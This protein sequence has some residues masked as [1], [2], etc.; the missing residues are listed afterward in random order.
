MVRGERGVAGDTTVR[1]ATRRDGP[2]LAELCRRVPLA[3]AGQLVG[4]DYGP[5]WWPAF[6]MV[7][8]R[9]VFVAEHG[10]RI[11]GL[12][13]VT[14]LRARVDARIVRLALAG[15]T[16][17]EPA[18]QGTGVFGALHDAADRLTHRAAAEPCALVPVGNAPAA[19]LPST[20]R[21]WPVRYDQLFVD[22]GAV[23]CA[24]RDHMRG[25]S[26][27]DAVALLEHTYGQSALA[28]ADL[29]A[30]LA[31]RLAIEPHRY[32]PERL[33][34]NGAAVLGVSKLAAVIARDDDSTPRRQITAFDIAASSAAAL[35]ALV[36]AWCARLADDTDDLVVWASAPGP[37]HDVVAPLAWK[38]TPHA[39]DLG[40]TPPVSLAHRG[41]HIGASLL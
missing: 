30:D 15:P 23:A 14:L 32:G 35:D 33:L 27:G 31:Q 6:G 28:P 12:H 8:G 19:G 29:G 7:A 38:C 34:T 21:S 3:A 40:L 1:P 41:I 2:A 9:H 20:L 11:V 10:G 37:I 18:V 22:C 26:L 4:T 13:A 25:A 17:I 36:R 24:S 16:R 39:L 5:D